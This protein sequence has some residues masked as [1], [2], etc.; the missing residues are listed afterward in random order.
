MQPGGNMPD[1]NSEPQLQEEGVYCDP[2]GSGRG[3]RL[4]SHIP[5]VLSNLT[6]QQFVYPLS[7]S[8]PY[9]ACL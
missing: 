6:V 5:E 4:R 7:Q 1:S 2:S 3:H 9:F 8:E